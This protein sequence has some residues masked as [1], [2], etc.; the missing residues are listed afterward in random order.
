MNL[1]FISIVALSVVFGLLAAWLI[2]RSKRSLTKAHNAA[3]RTW[4]IRASD[5]L[6]KAIDYLGTRREWRYRTP[7]MLVLGERGSG[8]TSL[9]ASIGPVHRLKLGA[10]EQE[11]KIE[12]VR[13]DFLVKG[14]LID[15]SGVEADDENARSRR[16]R[17]VLDGLVNLRPERAIDGIV[18]TVSAAK[19]LTLNEDQLRDAAEN[20]YRQLCDVQDAVEFVLPI[21]LVVTACDTVTGYSAFWNAVPDTLRGQMIGWSAPPQADSSKPEEWVESAFDLLN[22][23]LKAMQL[24]AAAEREVIGDVDRFFL[25]P[26]YGQQLRRPLTDWLKIVMRISPWQGG[27]LFRGIYFTGS[28][29]ADGDLQAGPR[30]DVQFVDDLVSK[31]IL[32]EPFLARPAR[33]GLWSR[34]DLL[35]RAQYAVVSLCLLFFVALGVQG[36]LLKEQIEIRLDSL[37]LID[38]DLNKLVGNACPGKTEVYALTEQIG[39]VEARRRYLFMPLSWFDVFGLGDKAAKRIARDAFGA[40]IMPGLYCQL[41]RRADELAADMEKEPSSDAL[42]ADQLLRLQALL[43]SRADQVNALEKAYA[44]FHDLAL[45]APLV[46]SDK[47]MAEF[48]DLL[49]Y[50]YG[51][52]PPASIYERN[53]IFPAA[54]TQVEYSRHQL[55]KPPARDLFATQ[56]QRLSHKLSA[57][58]HKEVKS[59]AASLQALR[60]EREP[61]LHYTRH[62]TWWLGWVRKSWLGSTASNNPCA[63]ILNTI[64]ATVVPLVSLNTSYASL[65]KLGGDFDSKNCYTP[66]MQSL[67]GEKLDPYGPLFYEQQ[68]TLALNP[69]LVPELAGL[70]ALV[71]L[72]FMQLSTV[73]PFQCLP[74]TSIWDTASLGAANRYLREYQGFTRN[75]N[76]PPLNTAADQRPLFDRLARRQLE[77]VL[78]STLRE[79]QRSTISPT[80]D[81]SPDPLS[82][83]DRQLDQESKAFS[84]SLEPLTG[85]GM[86]YA[87]LGFAASGTHVTKCARAFA[88]ERLAR[89]R[90]LADVSRL[91]VPTLS[92][93][94]NVFFPPEPVAVTRDY[95]ARQNSRAQVLTGYSSPFV[96]YLQNSEGGDD[97]HRQRDETL[98]FWSNTIGELNRFQQFKEP[99]GQVG[100][101][102]N[103]FLKQFVDLTQ[104]NCTKTL[105]AYKP[106]EHGNDLFSQR[107]QQ[108]EELVQVR[109]VDRTQ[110]VAFSAYREWADRFNRELAGRYPFGDAVKAPEA[111]L[112]AVRAFFIDYE[113]QRDSV[114]QALDSLRD[115]RWRGPK[116]F[117]DSLDETAAFFRSNLTAAEGYG[118]IRLSVAFRALPKQSPGSEQIVNWSLASG[119]TTISYPNQGTTLDWRYGQSLVLD[120]NWAERS[121]WRPVVDA[122]QSSLVVEG[123]T[124]SFVESSNW[125]LLRFMQAHKPRVAIVNDPGESSRNLLEFS[126]PV[127]ANADATKVSVGTARLYLG[128]SLASLD[129]KTQAP[130]PMGTLPRFPQYAPPVEGFNL[131]LARFK[132]AP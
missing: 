101:L 22:R 10:R 117:L 3:S 121:A 18:L 40:I 23:R 29:A 43:A 131:L 69:L 42:D 66:S 65:S 97:A 95:L 129:A 36:L 132:P 11:L 39:K 67:R 90:R 55:L 28:V 112:A 108:M 51:D 114:R 93:D 116:L 26:R 79:A 99:S 86:L 113:A 106:A 12:G 82:L 104:S 109:C 52:E 35:R 125:S 41:E 53:S 17:G 19:L 122:K 1:L 15:P 80:T 38:A 91:Y 8:K 78:N 25:F 96:K 94:E 57:Q 110:A 13:F 4:L 44:N 83:A 62:F 84:K 123:N 60:Q 27:F 70:N 30:T 46:Q 73:L 120:L 74:N 128:L 76:L 98:V 100:L 6:W 64:N 119:D 24:A 72:D 102:E 48:S 107:R 14:V 61:I 7:W 31:K 21:Y 33:K 58:L 50:L 5:S 118:P 56:L 37:Q 127:V 16:W 63:D 89:I 34:S 111:A 45:D 54:L 124:A 85:V 75:Q 130:I 2:V 59:G 88:S 87:Q 71:Q 77:R 47:Y 115:T 68:G 9:L 81:T 103:L 92:S 105:A 32:A 20:A 49:R 126:V